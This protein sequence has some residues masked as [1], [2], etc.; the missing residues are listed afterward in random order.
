MIEMGPT[1][2]APRGLVPR[3]SSAADTHHCSKLSILK[4]LLLITICIYLNHYICRDTN[5]SVEEWKSKFVNKTLEKVLH[6]NL[7]FFQGGPRVNPDTRSDYL[8]SFDKPDAPLTE[9]VKNRDI[10]TIPNPSN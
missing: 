2:L 1:P 4:F 10:D 6:H 5:K 9:D 7:E 8:T 3:N